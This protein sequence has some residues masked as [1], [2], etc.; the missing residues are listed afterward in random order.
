MGH[1]PLFAYLP[2][3][4]AAGWPTPAGPLE[5]RAQVSPCF[6]TT[7]PTG[8]CIKCELRRLRQ[9]AAS[10]PFGKACL[11]PTPIRRSHRVDHPTTHTHTHTHTH[12]CWPS[13]GAP[14]CPLSLWGMYWFSVVKTRTAQR[15]ASWCAS[16]SLRACRRRDQ[17]PLTH[18]Y[19]RPARPV[20][21]GFKHVCLYL[22]TMS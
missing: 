22:I 7:T 20:H 3:H 10:A 4:M 21:H 1:H 8:G 17:P 15:I 12:A 19:A 2:S 6:H 16:E 9:K 11:L 18:I 13:L 5:Q 14:C